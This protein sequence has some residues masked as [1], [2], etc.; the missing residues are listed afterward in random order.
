MQVAVDEAAVPLGDGPT[1]MDP[2]G[3]SPQDCGTVRTKEWVVGVGEGVAPVQDVG[4]VPS[5]PREVTPG[6]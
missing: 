2:L 4:G 3:D 1:G 5:G 6:R